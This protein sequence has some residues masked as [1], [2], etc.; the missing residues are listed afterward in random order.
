MK[1]KYR[2]KQYMLKRFFCVFYK[3]LANRIAYKNISFDPLEYRQKRALISY[4]VSPLLQGEQCLNM[5]HTNAPEAGVIIKEFIRRGYCVDVI[6]CASDAIIS[7]VVN[8]RYDIIFGSGEP[9][10]CVALQNPNAKKIIYLT[11]A[12][13]RTY[14]G[15]EIERLSYYYNRHHIRKQ[16]IR[17]GKFYSDEQISIADMG[18]VIGNEWTKSTFNYFHKLPIK[19]IKPTGLKN[20]RFCFDTI[21]PSKNNFLWFGSNGAILKGLDILLD[22]FTELPECNLYIC[23]L[24]S[25]EMD[26]L[27]AY[28]SQ[29]NIHLVGY[30]NV[31]SQEFL[32]IV[33]K[34]M[35]DIFPSGGEGM[36]TSVLTCMRHGMI[37]VVTK[38]TGVD[39]DDGMGYSLTDYHVEYLIE[40][41]RKLKDESDEKL[42]AMRERIYLY[43]NEQFCLEY[44]Q[45]QLSIIMDE[46]EV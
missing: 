40:E 19:K 5:P 20:S 38:E 31:Q 22:A 4:L 8:E 28:K 30:V 36:A 27:N 42:H 32:N 29:K 12:A 23:G 35:F 10:Y 24:P 45:A 44:F 2:I 3:Y 43:A 25:K 39:V 1:M 7:N 18:I 16:P 15:N 9:F 34:C 6:T 26:I 11:E 14:I 21:H 33:S 41:I 37:P 46:M 13:P 17:G